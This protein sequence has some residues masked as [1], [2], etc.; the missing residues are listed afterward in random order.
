MNR[1][2]AYVDVTAEFT[3]DGR[4]IPKK[5]KWEDGCVYE[6]S[7]V[8]DIRRAASLVAGG[9]GMRYTCIISGRKSFL[10]LEDTKRWFVE[11]KVPENTTQ[12][13]EKTGR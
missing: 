12:N 9:T 10:F 3:K 7:R 11:R 13:R 8:T 4:L 5:L 2:K 6:V 1:F